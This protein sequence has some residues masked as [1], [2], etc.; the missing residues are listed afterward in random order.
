MKRFILS[1]LLTLF[2]LPAFAGDSGLYFN[3]KHLGQGLTMIRQ[4]NLV[5]FNIFD[6]LHR[7]EG[8]DPLTVPENSLA[9][10]YD[11]SLPVWFFGADEITE[12]N[13]VLQGFIYAGVGIN[14]PTGIAD[15]RNPFVSIH[16]ENLL[17]GVYRLERLN[18]AAGGWILAVVRLGNV[19]PANTPIY[20]TTVYS[21]RLVIADEAKD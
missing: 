11:C 7:D 2:T 15:V 19:L 6:S 17:I 10:N 13:Q 3:P 9:Y 20:G 8:C 16:S 21:H 18:T 4:G 5:F 12:D 1:T 14:A